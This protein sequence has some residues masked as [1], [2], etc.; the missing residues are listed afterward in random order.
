MGYYINTDAP[1]MKGLYIVSN[2]GGKFVSKDEA[3]RA[4]D[5][6]KGVV[7]VVDNGFFEAAGFCFNQQEFEAFTQ[8]TDHRRK[9][10]V[11]MD[12]QLA[13]KLSGYKQKAGTIS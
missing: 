9:Q 2:H 10:F 4:M 5:E 13:E 12:R 1:F 3:Q 7:A 11:V 8:P 6:G